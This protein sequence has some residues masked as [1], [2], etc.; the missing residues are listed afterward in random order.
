MAIHWNKTS[1]YK[2]TKYT[3]L[4]IKFDSLKECRR[5]TELRLLEQAGKIKD[6]ELQKAYELIPAQYEE[7]AEIYTKGIRKGEPK[8]GKLLERACYYVA[9][10]YYIDCETGKTVV[11]DV[12]GYREGGAYALFSVKRKLMLYI[13]HIKVKEL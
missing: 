9:D 6:L 3:Y 2:N 10:F 1:K 13:Y 8:Q 11:E 7:T 12:K 5:Y 4:G